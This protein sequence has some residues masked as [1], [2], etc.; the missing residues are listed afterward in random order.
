MEG[1]M[2][3]HQNCDCD[4]C[5]ELASRQQKRA[6][7]T[8]KVA[9]ALADYVNHE[10]DPRYFLDEQDYDLRNADAVMTAK[11]LVQTQTWK[12]GIYLRHI[13][14]LIVVGLAIFSGHVQAQAP[15]TKTEVKRLTAQAREEVSRQTKATSQ[16]IVLVKISHG[17]FRFLRGN[18]LITGKC[19]NK[20]GKCPLAGLPG[21]VVKEDVSQTCDGYKEGEIRYGIDQSHLYFSR[22]GQNEYSK[23]RIVQGGLYGV[24]ADGSTKV[25]DEWNMF[26]VIEMRTERK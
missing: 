22:F 23:D 25:S 15:E 14:A 17:V 7:V 9:S 1:T 6:N 24:Q 18:T 13:I 2:K 20:D 26:D 5:N 21:T 3:D 10:D 8:E 19:A 11:K 16:D 12:D 4:G